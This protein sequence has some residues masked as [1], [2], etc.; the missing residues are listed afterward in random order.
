[1][2][3]TKE[4]F[5]AINHLIDETG[6]YIE[7]QAV[8]DHPEKASTRIEL[9]VKACAKL[10]SSHF[11]VVHSHALE[12][13]AQALSFDSWRSLSHHLKFGK[14][15]GSDAPDVLWAMQLKHCIFLLAYPPHDISLS[16]DLADAYVKFAEDIGEVSGLSAAVILN[17]VCS[18]M[19][20]GKS[21]EEVTFRDPLDASEPYFSFKDDDYDEYPHLVKSE[22][23]DALTSKM[24]E[25]YGD[26]YGRGGEPDYAAIYKLCIQTIQKRPDF[27]SGYCGIAD[28]LHSIEKYEEAL[29][30]VNLGLKVANQLVPEEYKGKVEAL[31]RSNDIYCSLI[32]S[33]ME[34]EFELG[35]YDKSI[36]SARK[37]L[38][39]D[40]R[41]GAG[42]RML[43]PFILLSAQDY[44]T[45]RKV[46]VFK[47]QFGTIMSLAKSFSCFAVSDGSGYL[48][49]LVDALLNQ[50]NCKM[51]LL[52]SSDVL[53]VGDDG[54]RGSE[55]G[56]FYYSSYIWSAYNK[57]NNL[58]SVTERVLGSEL[59][60]TAEI[61]LFNYWDK[62]RGAASKKHTTGN[63]DE[64][65]ALQVKWKNQLFNGLS[66]VIE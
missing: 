40:S 24:K 18:V 9:K 38:R 10:I 6:F 28:Y 31:F 57:V 61:E 44:S 23:C 11:D 42:V 53:P 66:K 52:N 47:D 2:K 14:E 15:A 37:H 64:W 46:S 41:D 58:R 33:K 34:C 26:P 35:L 49:N 22:A 16:D 51:M 56:W 50:P 21:W 45:A 48:I 32:H 60:N 19:C 43:L 27:L 8:F 4:H 65:L 1:M 30:Y 3:F 5:S 54:L 62:F 63:Y 39:I 12:H 59:F 29:S 25:L 13:I 36:A 20:N 17:K 7:P 55:S